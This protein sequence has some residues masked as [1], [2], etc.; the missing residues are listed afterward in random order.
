MNNLIML[1]NHGGG[2]SYALLEI[3]KNNKLEINTD[4]KIL[5]ATYSPTLKNE[6]LKSYEEEINY[7][8]KLIS[9]LSNNQHLIFISSQTLELTNKT[10]YSK[11]KNE[12]ENI[13]KNNCN[14]FTI[15]RPGMIFDTKRKKFTLFSMEKSSKS[16]LT[17]FQDVP[18]TTICSIIDIYDCINLISNDLDYFCG[19]TINIG[20]QRYTFEGLQN[21]STYKN[22]RFPVVPFILLRLLSFF[23]TRLTA[24]TNGRGLSDVSSLA[25]NS[26]L[27]QKNN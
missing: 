1:S 5:I 7:Y 21:V 22:F 16:I 3:I 14:S 18:K 26:M 8:R 4:K 24:Y 20:I 2:L 15:L 9:N 13:L 11:A 12:I 25:F 10:L 17:F 19:K 23:S 27:D 6:S